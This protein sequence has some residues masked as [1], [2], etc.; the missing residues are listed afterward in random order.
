[1]WSF[2]I[3]YISFKTGTRGLGGLS[4]NSDAKPVFKHIV[5]HMRKFYASGTYSLFSRQISDRFT[6]LWFV[7]FL[8]IVASPVANW[9]ASTNHFL[10]VLGKVSNPERRLINLCGQA[11]KTQN[12][13]AAVT[14]TKCRWLIL[15]R[16]SAINTS[17]KLL[18][19]SNITLAVI[20]PLLWN[21]R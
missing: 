9:L 18:L 12:L 13:F 20:S 14:L 15:M 7:F 17:F 1:M 19:P 11:D 10:Q 3:S 4:R 21:F 16:T 6:V 8:Y 5:S 2:K